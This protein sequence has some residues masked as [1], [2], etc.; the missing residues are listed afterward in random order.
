MKEHLIECYHELL[1]YERNKLKN[2]GDIFDDK[3]KLEEEEIDNIVKKFNLSI[4]DLLNEGLLVKYPEG[5][6]RTLHYDMIF[7]IVNIRAYED[8]GSKLPL[9]YK[10]YQEFVPL[11]RF[12]EASI[13]ELNISN[14][15]KTAIH[16]K[17]KSISKFQLIY[18]NKI[19]EGK[20]KTYVISSPTGSGK[21]LIFTIPI[22]EASI[23]GYKSILV[24]PRKALAS[25]QLM[26]LIE[27][28][29]LLNE[30]LKKGGKNQ[31][32]IGI[33]DGDTPKSEIK[34]GEEFRGIR[35][36]ICKN[37]GREAKLIY[38]REGNNTVIKCE[39]GH[40]FKFIIPTKNEIWK[41]EP[42]ILVTNVQTLNRRLM[43]PQAQSLFKKEIKYL[44][45]DESHVYREE[46]G[47]HVHFVIKRLKKKLMRN[48]DIEPQIILSSATLPKKTLLYFVSKLLEVEENE[49]FWEDYNTLITNEKK[50]CVIHLF[51]LPNP[52][53]SAEV[54]AENVLLFLVEWSY[55][56]GKKSI[57][58]VDSV[59][60]I[61]RLRKFVEV[62]IRRQIKRN[63]YYTNYTT[64]A[65]EHLNPKLSENDPYC[66]KHY[67]RIS[68]GDHTSI[69]DGL[70]NNVE[71]HHGSLEKKERFIIE[72]NFKKGIKKCL[73]ATSTLELGIDV[74][75]VGVI[76]H[77]RYPLSKESYVQR[78]GRAGRSEDSYFT[79]LSILIL[80][81]SPSQLKYIYDE[82]ISSAISLPDDFILPLS[83]NNEAIKENHKFFEFL[84][85]LAS[86][87]IPTF[88]QSSDIERYWRNKKYLMII[89]SIEKLLERGIT[90][91]D[92][93]LYNL[94]SNYLNKLR[95]KKP[96][97]E[98][99]GNLSPEE[100]ISRSLFFKEAADYFKKAEDKLKKVYEKAKLNLLS[101]IPECIEI[102]LP[103]I[104]YKIS[105]INRKIDDLYTHFRS[106]N[107]YSFEKCATDVEKM[108][109]ELK[110]FVSKE[111]WNIDKELHDFHSKII[112]KNEEK[113]RHFMLDLRKRLSDVIIEI[114]NL[115]VSYNDIIAHFFESP[116]EIEVRLR[117]KEYW[118][119][120]IAE[121]MNL[122]RISNYPISLL[123]DKPLK[124]VYIRYVGLSDD[125]EEDLE[126]TEKTIDK[127]FWFSAPFYVSPIRNHY[128]TTIYGLHSKDYKIVGFE[129]YQA[130]R[131]GDAFTF[132]YMNN[133]FRAITP[134]FVDMLDLNKTIISAISKRG[135]TKSKLVLSNNRYL[136]NY[137]IDKCRFCRYGLF[138]TTENVDS[139]TFNECGL[140]HKCRGT[141]YFKIPRDQRTSYLG[142]VKVYPQIYTS[143]TDFT[144]TIENFS[145]DSN[146]SVIVKMGK[147]SKFSR[148]MT[149]VCIFSKEFYFPIIFT[150]SKD[151]IGYEISS[152]G[153]ALQFDENIL[154]SM[155]EKIIKEKD[156]IRSW[157]IV[158]YL[159]SKK[160]FREEGNVNLELL[161]KAL[162]GLIGFE[163]TED[164]KKEF[165]SK[166][167]VKDIKKIREGE[168]IINFASFLIL[169]SLS[170]LLYEYLL[171][172]LKTNP[173]NLLY[174]VDEKK[175]KIY[176]IENGERGLGLTD[177]LLTMIKNGKK[178]FF[179]DFFKWSL[180]ITKKCEYI[181]NN[182]KKGIKKEFEERYNYLDE[183][184]KKE[185]EEI[186]DKIRE[187]N[188][189]LREYKITI[190]VEILRNILVEEFGDKPIIMEAISLNTSYCWDGCYNCVRLERG[191][192]Y[193][194][195]SQMTR[196]SKNLTSEFIER[197]LKSMNISFMV[198]IGFEWVLDEIMKAKESVRIASPWL[199]KEIFQ[200]YIEPLLERGVKVKVLTKKDLDNEE[201]FESLRYLY[202]LT[203]KYKNLEV[204]CFDSLHA[205]MI[206]VDNRIAIKG[207][208]NLTLAGIY[209]NLELVEK[210]ENPSTVEYLIQHFEK[211]YLS[212][213]NLEM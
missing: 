73:L 193:D 72:E 189:K 62:I 40:D 4:L 161:Q 78:V 43:E 203:K 210:D 127:I 60:E 42:T 162:K 18:I 86:N 65:L 74:G 146:N 55:L 64:R 129:N 125:E 63:H 187:I 113:L 29:T 54:L 168:D 205:K 126:R 157:V 82:D 9:E 31:I 37:N 135:I 101:D 92:V 121:V 139:C 147:G 140:Y 89:E 3:S 38:S 99:S 15:L 175:C 169:H 50:K 172:K 133:K 122:L 192:K 123:F 199:S 97:I 151:T 84:D 180:E 21:T 77:Y 213:E 41:S 130:L 103:K 19:L 34:E 104:I 12:D 11:P 167:K 32:T 22:L 70:L 53:R 102:L 76:A 47:G 85:N 80:T 108:I 94:L 211:L 212:A 52:F 30:I 49:I 124:R 182:Y 48:T 197:L 13:D 142:L 198:G 204:M 153:I 93:E 132:E 23:K 188:E 59:E 71:Y 75:D 134:D 16:N 58:F 118:K 145:L 116:I 39:N 56:F 7:R 69:I 191:C 177:T 184:T 170:H 131:G 51:L 8:M 83:I 148:A 2:N 66:W 164:F 111:E 149:G 67:S 95:E 100:A 178:E 110:D 106:N 138:L 24:Y 105:Q 144:N 28:T 160:Y 96:F 27:Y 163:G 181:E 208:M 179:I 141:K 176:I 109:N 68:L 128:F 25:D 120:N 166:F 114:K 206:L 91:S 159:I 87:G 98:K 200:K 117:D 155:V 196:V 46:L 107:M 165:E 6:F 61:R 202:S 79:A 35:C 10:I 1:K 119:Y 26:N 154:K 185:F 44:I 20:H 173:D 171:D 201:Q 156:D 112:E 152:N 90:T 150:L 45:F 136:G 194:P 17:I 33:D 137:N 36:P 209:K 88:I 174:H 143:A 158:K 5:K 186:S 81:N 57:F 190:P 207:S 14:E 115:K 195:F 183:K